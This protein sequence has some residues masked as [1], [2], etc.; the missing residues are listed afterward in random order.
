MSCLRAARPRKFLLAS[1]VLSSFAAFDISAVCAQQA[2]SREQL[3][4]VEISPPTDQKRKPARPSARDERGARRAAANRAA[5]PA[6]APKPTGDGTQTP[7]NTNA[8]AASAS[9]LGLA[10]REVP[11]TVEVISA[12]TIREQGYRTVSEVAQGAV[13]VTSGDNPAEPSAFSMRGFTN[14]Q[15]N[16]LYNGIKIGPQNMTSRIM[17][18]ANLEAVE[19]LKGPASLLSGEGASGGAVNFVTKQPHTGPI[20]TQRGAGRPSSGCVSRWAES[21]RCSA[22]SASSTNSP[23]RTTRTSARCGVT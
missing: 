11:A 14:S 4:P 10:V 13:G 17:D 6:T 7:L 15:I 5:S 8:I 21:G 19:F 16:V 23:A 1:G 22:R 9:S 12:E 2:G 18:T 3:S 20:R